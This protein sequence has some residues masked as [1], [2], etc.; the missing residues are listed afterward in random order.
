MV[1][2]F[3]MLLA[4]EINPTPAAALVR[5]EIGVTVQVEDSMPK[6]N[7]QPINRAAISV[8]LIRNRQSVRNV[9]VVH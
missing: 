3:E 6:R 5:S 1:Q 8:Y 7:I 4:D 9:L 2:E